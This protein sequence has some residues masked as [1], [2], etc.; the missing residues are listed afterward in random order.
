[1]NAETSRLMGIKTK[2]RRKQV[3]P[4]HSGIRDMWEL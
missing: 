2:Q 1:M 4:L 3:S